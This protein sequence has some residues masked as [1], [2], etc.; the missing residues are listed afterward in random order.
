MGSSPL[1]HLWRILR[2]GVYG[3]TAFGSI[4]SFM[5]AGMEREAIHSRNQEINHTRA[6]AI[7]ETEANAD[8]RNTKIREG[9]FIPAETWYVNSYVY[10]EPFNLAQ[11]GMDNEAMFPNKPARAF[12]ANAV[13]F[14]IYYPDGSFDFVDDHP[15]LSEK[16]L[17][18][19]YGE[20]S[21]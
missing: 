13:F 1:H 10:P 6:A 15:E 8:I 20:A 4:L 21:E 3:A 9:E 14:G 7:K 18:S 17:N 19:T 5:V 12:D 16:Y 11:H 2:F